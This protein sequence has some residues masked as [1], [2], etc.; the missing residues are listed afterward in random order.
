LSRRPT[1][2]FCYQQNKLA[3]A[4][5]E[6]IPEPFRALIRELCEPRFLRVLEQITGIQQ[7][8][9]D[10]YLV[11]GGLHLSGPGGVLSPHTDFH[12]HRALNLY[13]RIN[14]LVYLNQGW[15]LEDGGYL[16]LYDRYG[17]AV[18]TVVPQWG[19]TVIFRTDDQ[20]VHGFPVPV[21]EGKW[22]RSVALY[23]YTAAPTDNFSGD[24]TTYW[25][26]HGELAGVVR[27]GRFLAYRGLLRLSR[28]ISILAHIMNPN[29]GL[30]RIALA[31]RRKAKPP[32]TETNVPTPNVACR[33]AHPAASPPAVD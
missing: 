27:K 10:P 9:P 26:E 3:C 25:R 30:L 19:R 14:V 23:Y 7:L 32:R 21:V 2:C 5:L 15:S 1:R 17:R 22:R 8:L 11:G 28:A 6:L 16:S 31:G 29:V 12:Y 24:E 4:D 33:A 18:Q 13:R 20:S